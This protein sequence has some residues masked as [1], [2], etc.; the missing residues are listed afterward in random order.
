MSKKSKQV[1]GAI[2]I[3]G[4]STGI[5]YFCAKKLHSEKFHVLATARKPEDVERLRQEGLTAHQL[6]VDDKKSIEAGLN[7]AI[8]QSN[9][10]LYALFNNA[11]FGLVAAVEDLS[12]EALQAQFSTNV[13]GT[14]YLTNRFIAHVRA[15]GQRARIIYNSSVL[16]FVSLPFRG[17]YN[18]SKYAVEGFAD[19]LRAELDCDDLRICSIQPG[20]IVSLFRKNA[21]AALREW[22]DCD[23]SVHRAL[24]EQHL[25]ASEHKP[26]PFM[27][28][29]EAVYKALEHALIAPKPKAHYRVT[30]PTHL[31]WLLKRILPARAL[32]YIL[33]KI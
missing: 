19:S 10:G 29:P 2:L 14:Q 9:G 16:G 20:P 1:R 5:G 22:V 25:N 28:G 27:L 15:G 12:Y 18:A 3:T 31:F 11:G 13:L 26:L 30:F 4:C 24:Y 23:G 17:G 33:R 7:W 32:D 6:D 21:I 8:E